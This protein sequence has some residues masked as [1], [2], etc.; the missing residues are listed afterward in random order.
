MRK[1]AIFLILALS[2]CSFTA[3]RDV[4]NAN[5]M[6]L[7]AL[8][9]PVL[10]FTSKNG[11]TLAY[12]DS[13]SNLDTY[14]IAVQ[15]ADGRQDY[16]AGA[17][18]SDFLPQLVRSSVQE[19]LFNTHAFSTVNNDETTSIQRYSLFIT[20]QEMQAV[21]EKTASNPVIS[22][23][24]YVRLTD[25]K[26]HKIVKEKAVKEKI[27]ATTNDLTHI[28]LAFDT[29]FANAQSEILG[30]MWEINQIPSKEIKQKRV[31]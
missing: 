10:P 7:H 23:I 20:I 21:Y 17:R 26:T 18:W 29:A 14:R 31:E 12:P 1:I 3:P 8:A 16:F 4:G 9:N 11:I 15:R 27:V 5:R 28:I 6:T 24:F 30:T 2:C 19:T 25:N 13:E 22:L